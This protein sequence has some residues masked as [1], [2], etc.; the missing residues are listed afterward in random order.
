MRK[1]EGPKGAAKGKQTN[2]MASCQPLL[3]P[4]DPCSPHRAVKNFLGGKL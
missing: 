3:P 2:T 4:S 1:G